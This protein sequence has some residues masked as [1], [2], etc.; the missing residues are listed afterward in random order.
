MEEKAPREISLLLNPCS[1]DEGYSAMFPS[2]S[3]VV[4]FYVNKHKPE[5]LFIPTY[6]IL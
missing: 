6:S 5:T 3:K 1:G 2:F 4:M